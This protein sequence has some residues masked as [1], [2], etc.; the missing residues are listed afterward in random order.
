MATHPNILP[1]VPF[2]IALPKLL[3]VFPLLLGGTLIHLHILIVPSLLDSVFPIQCKSHWAALFLSQR[4]CT[5]NSL[6][7]KLTSQLHKN[8]GLGP[9]DLA[10]PCAGVVPIDP[11]ILYHIPSTHRKAG[12]PCSHKGMV[13]ANDDT[14]PGSYHKPCGAQ[15]IGHGSH[16][17][18]SAPPPAPH[19]SFLLLFQNEKKPE[20]A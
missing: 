11:T 9:S 16:R 7:P 15:A 5:G 20:V 18:T 6:C 2:L 13:T 3:F 19:A 12:W 10:S 17:G 4:I 8:Q 1:T 14:D